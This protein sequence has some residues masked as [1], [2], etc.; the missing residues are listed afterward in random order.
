MDKDTS[1]LT[2]IM[3]QLK[4]L[5]EKLD[6]DPSERLRKSS[7]SSHRPLLFGFT[8]GDSASGDEYR[9]YYA[10]LDQIT[11]ILNSFGIH[12]G[13]SGYSYLIDAVKIIIDMENCDVRM[14]SDVYPL[15]SA[16]Y[17]LRNPAIVEHSIRN[18]INTAYGDY[19]RD[20]GCNNMGEFRRKPTNKQFIIYA[21]D[22]AVRNMFES[23]SRDAC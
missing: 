12:I 16:R 13:N 8:S 11:E 1:I 3:E 6:E 23:M 18:A 14:K 22:N 4:E 10:Y 9:R 2:G 15:I 20:P 19:L 21:A 17:R 7:V 5:N